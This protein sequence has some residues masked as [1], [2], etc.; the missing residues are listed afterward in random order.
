MQRPTL[1][2]YQKEWRQISHKI[3]GLPPVQW[4][5]IAYLVLQKMPVPFYK[6]NEL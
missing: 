1:Q 5:E 6:K 3:Q 2:A 4:N